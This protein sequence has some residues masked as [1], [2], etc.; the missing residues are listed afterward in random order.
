MMKDYE[1]Q[2]TMVKSVVET[3]ILPS[4]ISIHVEP[5]SKHI[6]M[7]F[8]APDN[9]IDIKSVGI[10]VFVWGKSAWIHKRQTIMFVDDDVDSWKDALQVACNIR[11]V[12]RLNRDTLHSDSP[13]I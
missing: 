3:V 8:I 12:F 4:G 5:V 10:C 11:N 2:T 6:A 7:V 9:V 13:K 1:E